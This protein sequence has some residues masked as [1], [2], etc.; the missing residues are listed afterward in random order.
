MHSDTGAQNVDTSL[1]V[2]AQKC[3][4]ISAHRPVNVIGCDPTDWLLTYGALAPVSNCI[5]NTRHVC[6]TCMRQMS[7]HWDDEIRFLFLSRKKIVAYF[8]GTE[9][10]SILL[11]AVG[12]YLD[13]TARLSWH[14]FLAIEWGSLPYKHQQYT[15]SALCT[16]IAVEIICYSCDWVALVTSNSVQIF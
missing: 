16:R 6:F 7:M 3:P 15:S 2:F 12:I 4:S 9:I 10:W 5:Q 11:G 14:G 1:R 13:S 8:G